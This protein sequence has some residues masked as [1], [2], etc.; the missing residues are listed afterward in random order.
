MLQCF[1]N[2]AGKRIPMKMAAF[3][4]Q[5]LT[6]RSED[7]RILNFRFGV[8]KIIDQFLDFS[9]SFESCPL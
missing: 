9:L 7:A 1:E 4:V 5:A 2:W 8:D 6:R 3:A